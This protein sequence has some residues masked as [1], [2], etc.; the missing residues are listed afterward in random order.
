[1][2][3]YIT[4]P[5]FCLALIFSH[6]LSVLVYPRARSSRPFVK[7]DASL[8]D[9]Q[10]S[11]DPEQALGVFLALAAAVLLAGEAAERREPGCCAR[12]KNWNNFFGK[13]KVWGM[14]L[15]SSAKLLN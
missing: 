10:V 3:V 15:R 6:C 1:M 2:L 12:L 9:E 7:E 14:K 5:N 11:P 8:S 13:I 4:K